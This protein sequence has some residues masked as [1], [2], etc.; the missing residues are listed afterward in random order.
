MA[1]SAF[2]DRTP[3]ARVRVALILTLSVAAGLA[4]GTVAGI[5]TLPP[6]GPAGVAAASG[7]PLPSASGSATDGSPVTPAPTGPT[8]TPVPTP[9]PTPRIVAAPLTGVPVAPEVAAQHPIAVII[10]DHRDARPQAGLS[11]AAVVWHA[12]AEGG[13]PRYLAIFQESLPTLVGPVRSAR[14]YFIEWAAETRALFVHVGGSPEALATLRSEGGGQLVYAVDEFSHGGGYLWR[15]ADRSVPHNLYTD[16][17]RLRALA[18]VAGATDRVLDPAWRFGPGTPLSRR[19][20]GGSIEVAYRVNTIR[21]DYDRA[22]NTYPRTVTGEPDGQVDAGTGRRVAPSNVVIMLVEFAPLRDGH[23]EKGR[24]EADVIG[25]GSAW[26][27]TGGRTI[28]G[29]WRKASTIGS[30]RFF[31]T[32]GR[33]VALNPGQ[34]FVQVLETGSTVTIVPGVS[35]PPLTV[36]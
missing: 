31:D 13:I 5:A 35:P 28:E 11:E 27:A 12:P 32:N 6:P 21:Y 1:E 23:P 18:A 8:P 19:P 36:D 10:D 15:T 4:I 26:I 2:D 33:P 22:S 25:S 9:R 7:I 29:R 3:T 16:G 24:L 14:Q 34:T 17:Q 30:T 20:L